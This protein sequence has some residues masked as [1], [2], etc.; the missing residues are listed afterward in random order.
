MTMRKTLLATLAIFAI[1]WLAPLSASAHHGTSNYDITHT[2]TVTGVVTDFQWLNPHAIV[3]FDV[4]DAHGN[5]EKW[6]CDA[7][8]P[9]HLVKVG[10][11]R[12]TLKPGDRITATGNVTKSG[13][14]VIRVLKIVL[15]NGQQLTG[16]THL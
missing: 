14:H 1:V 12:H 6:T 3:Y 9:S 8:G 13:T 2:T 15:A 16:Y 10:W 5:L 4:K 11:N 7:P